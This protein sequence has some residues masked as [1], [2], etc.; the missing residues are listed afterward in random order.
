MRIKDIRFKGR[1]TILSIQKTIIQ[2]MYPIF[3]SHSLK[4]TAKKG[5]KLLSKLYYLKIIKS[6]KL[7]IL[8]ISKVA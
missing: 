3:S 4:L 2:D 8:D 1:L 5:F 6:K 7:F